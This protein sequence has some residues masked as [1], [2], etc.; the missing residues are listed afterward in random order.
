MLYLIDANVLMTAHNSY[1]AIDAV[2][3][4]W[5]WIAHH[6]SAGRIKIPREIFDEVKD[7]GTDKESDMLYEWIQDANNK[8]CVLLKE[9]VDADLV[10]TVIEEGYASDLNDVEVE[11]IGRDPFLIAYALASPADRIVV[12]TEVS[13]PKKQRANRKIPDVC[14]QFGVDCIDTFQLSKALKFSTNWKDGS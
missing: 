4:F 2:P 8:A 7:G 13:Q 10:R 3:E 14:K 5:T 1:Y 9:K 6:G 12:T 11:K